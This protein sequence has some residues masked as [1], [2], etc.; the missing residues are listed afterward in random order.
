LQDLT[1]VSSTAP[2][3]GDNGKALVW[4]QAAG[5]WQAQ[6]VA[7]S[8][9]S[10]APTLGTIASQNANAVAITGGNLSG[11]GSVAVSPA[12]SETTAISV[13][14]SELPFLS[15]SNTAAASF[16]TEVYNSEF[17]FSNTGFE[18][19]RARGS[20]SSPS[21][22]Q[23]GDWVF[24][25]NSRPR[26]FSGWSSGGASLI[27]TALTTA[28]SGDPGNRVAM[29]ADWYLIPLSRDSTPLVYRMTAASFINYA[30]T[31]STSPSTGAMTV[32]GGV[33]IE[34]A[35]HVGGQINGL[36]AVQ[37]GTPASATAAG[38]AGQIRWD[39]DYI[40]V[41]TATNTWKRVAISTW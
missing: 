25:F 36:G 9:L 12:S 20:I 7:Y 6:Q 28:A 3:S 2:D 22:V 39:T 33:G 27:F 34:G 21:G 35:L 37:P 32:A 15:Q 8:N 31:P 29:A 23:A 38:T 4:N 5:R 17:S 41:C 11:L 16:L 30:T 18:G 24:V 40:Y 13:L 1:N 19:R 10:G 14:N 26:G